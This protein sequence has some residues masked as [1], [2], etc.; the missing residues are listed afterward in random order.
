MNLTAIFGKFAGLEVPMVERVEK[1]EIRGKTHEIP[2]IELADQDDPTVKEMREAA[3]QNG[4]N[5]RLW[6]EGTVGTMDFRT[7]RVNA[8]IERCSDG[9]WRVSREFRIG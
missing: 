6:W 4:L 5:L 7:D 2:V 1:L 3:A 9:K 8:T